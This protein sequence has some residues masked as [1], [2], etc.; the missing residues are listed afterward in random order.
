MVW[1]GA[2]ISGM[3]LVCV[4]RRLSVV[5][6]DSD[7]RENLSDEDWATMASAVLARSIKSEWQTLCVSLCCLGAIAILHGLVCVMLHR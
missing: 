4:L 5:R 6:N 3:K 1:Y 7:I 2:D